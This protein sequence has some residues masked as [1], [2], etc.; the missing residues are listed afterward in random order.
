MKVSG[1]NIKV[2]DVFDEYKAK[3]FILGLSAGA[4]VN[5]FRRIDVGIYFR[6]DLTKNYGDEYMDAGVFQNK[7]N[8]TWSVGLN[9]YF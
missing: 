9:Y 1:G 3:N 4:G 6:G 5:V 2:K 7:K 8:Q